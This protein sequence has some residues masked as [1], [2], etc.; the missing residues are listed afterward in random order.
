MNLSA[1][2]KMATKYINQNFYKE[3]MTNQEPQTRGFKHY[4]Q[5]LTNQT[6]LKIRMKMILIT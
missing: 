3:K 1:Y 2:N 6:Y 4:S 5:R